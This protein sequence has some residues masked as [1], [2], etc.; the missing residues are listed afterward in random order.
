[1]SL[2]FIF[3]VLV[4]R[5]TQIENLKEKSHYHFTVKIKKKQIK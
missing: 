1:M 3:T 5:T 4:S 2:K